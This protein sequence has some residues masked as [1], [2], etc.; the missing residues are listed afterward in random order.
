[1]HEITEQFGDHHVAVSGFRIHDIGFSKTS[2]NQSI[3]YPFNV[4]N[5]QRWMIWGPPFA[6][7]PH[8]EAAL[9]FHWRVAAVLLICSRDSL[10]PRGSGSLSHFED[11]VSLPESLQTLEM[12]TSDGK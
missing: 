3:D 4:K 1:M 8:L 9:L 6:E 7:A 11:S 2:K 5:D 12:T 10:G